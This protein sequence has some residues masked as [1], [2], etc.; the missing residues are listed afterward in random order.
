LPIQFLTEGQL[1]FGYQLSNFSLLAVLSILISWSYF[2]YR[3]VQNRLVRSSFLFLMVLRSIV[4][5]LLLLILLKPQV[6]LQYTEPQS[7][8]LAILVDLSKSMQITDMPNEESRLKMINQILFDERDGI[9]KKLEDNFKVRLFG[10]D[11]AAYPLAVQPLT[12]S[13]GWETDLE[14]AIRQVIK[15][16]HHLPLA[17]VVVLSDGVDQTR[18]QLPTKHLL[19]LAY[20][21]QEKNIPV[22]TVG[23]GTV[24]DLPDFILQPVEPLSNIKQNQPTKIPI[25]IQRYGRGISSSIQVCLVHQERVI[26][27]QI[28]QFPTDQRVKKVEIPFLPRK[29]GIEKYRVEI[30]AS[31]TIK[32]NNGQDLLLKI[33][34]SPRLN[35]LY[36]EG[37]PRQEFSF[38]KRVLKK[39][40]GIMLTDRYLTDYPTQH[41]F[42]FGGTK[43]TLLN[44]SS[45][46]TTFFPTD[47]DQLNTYDGLIIGNL[48]ASILTA[49]QQKMVYQYVSQRGG[50]LV[51]GGSASLGLDADW[52]S[53]IVRLLPIELELEQRPLVAGVFANRFQF[54]LTDD[55][56]R[57]PLL[58]LADD[59][60]DN[61]QQWQSLP[62]L[63]GYSRVKRAK[64]GAT[65]LATHSSDQNEFGMRIL[66][67]YHYYN[68]GRV[69]VFTPHN[70]WR[71]Q[72]MTS[73]DDTRYHRFWR[74]IVRWLG[75]SNRKQI[76]I[77][78]KSATY[79]LGHSIR[80]SSEV[81]SANYDIV[82]A[83]V[84]AYLTRLDET[85]AE[86]VYELPMY[87]S[88]Y[89]PGSY[90]AD[91][92]P[93]EHGSYK[94]KIQAVLHPNTVEAE[95]IE[96]EETQFS[97]SDDGRE[98]TN[99]T[100]NRSGLERLAQ[101]SGGQ[102]FSISTNKSREGYNP[103]SKLPD[104]IPFVKSDITN[105]R[106]IDLWDTPFIFVI[107][108]GLFCLEWF[109]RK[110]FGLA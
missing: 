72:M 45:I 91:F 16:L 3:F 8:Y 18:R 43:T 15:E 20:Q 59:S 82:P 37:H 87:P 101:A 22:H 62:E 38:I 49:E 88:L 55:G 44:S 67:A 107:L 78:L 68:E 5:L 94:A 11:S 56:R 35:I 10:F 4:L 28:V 6:S 54:T 86:S 106:Y 70:S 13:N 39:D 63:I 105:L 50:L 92:I 74:Q 103:V 9:Y 75:T 61:L 93:P 96:S 89:Q 40:P 100:L 57:N 17:G 21:L 83:L 84:T 41:P 65:I 31:D 76:M 47:L 30:R 42:I 29:A 110:Y 99:P 34:S 52:D 95:T 98:F 80:I 71:W 2:S 60:Y 108:V 81:R 23:V 97:V 32:Q 79:T 25:I 64:A 12:V 27:Q 77:D 53:M 51:L 66:L 58:T 104:K 1:T 48:P 14:V 69:M 85:T 7:A 102:Y 24:H 46:T 90:E 36:L 73:K 109:F 19:K 33:K 26:N